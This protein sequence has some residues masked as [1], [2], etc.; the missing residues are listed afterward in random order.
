MCTCAVLTPQSNYYFI[1]CYTEKE[2][3]GEELRFPMYP[4]CTS[5]LRLIMSRS[6]SSNDYTFVLL[7]ILVLIIFARGWCYTEDTRPLEKEE[8]AIVEDEKEGYEKEEEK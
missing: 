8:R 6:C 2:I 7:L 1:G 4:I 3:N 5:H